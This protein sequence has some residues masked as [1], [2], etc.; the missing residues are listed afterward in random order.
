M[1]SRV[2]LKES[3]YGFDHVRTSLM[4]FEINPDDPKS[5]T[6]YNLE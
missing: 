4:D 1:Q 5:V 6:L 3:P 2:I